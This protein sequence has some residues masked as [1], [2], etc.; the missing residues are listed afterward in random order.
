[1]TAQKRNERA[2]ACR[3]AVSGK[4][5]AMLVVLVAALVVG[6]M[7]VIPGKDPALPPVEISPVNVEVEIIDPLPELIDAFDLPGV[8]EANRVVKVSAEVA[9]R[10]ERIDCREGQPC[11]R[12]DKLIYL[13]TD[14]LQAE[15]DRAEAQAEYDQ[16]D[17]QRI[18]DAYKG[19]GLGATANEVDLAR[20][21][22]QT[23]RA[24]YQAAKATLQRATIVAPVD[25]ILN[26][27]PVEVGEYL[28]PGQQVAEIVDI[29]TAKVVVRVPERDVFY[30]KL[31]QT[32]TIFVSSLDSKELT[33][34]VS[35][36]S[37]LADDQTRTTRVEVE[38]DNRSRWLRSGQIVRA[39]MTRQVLKAVVMVPLDA[40]I[41]Q[42]EKK[43]VYVVEDGVAKYREVKIGLIQGSR[44]QILG[45]GL[46]AKEKLIVAGHRFVS[47]EQPVKIVKVVNE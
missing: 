34:T 18:A 19:S 13:N 12:G 4:L 15:Y 37:E 29:E 35:Y 11:R 31:G 45:D 27:L 30:V 9:G 39:R 3:G 42:E 6:V 10:V 28:Q 1:M 25:G 40:V 47:P 41:P 20:T 33:G 43:A 36:V 38:V 7:A 23:S 8:V 17:Y 22:A 14:L 5:V 46:R 2:P 32:Q 21:K 44:V 24:A 16:R 26:R